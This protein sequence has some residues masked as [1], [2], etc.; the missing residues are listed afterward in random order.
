S[1]QAREMIMRFAFLLL[2]EAIL[3]AA[4]SAQVPEIAYDSTPNFLK[5]PEHIYMGEAVGVASNSKGNVFVYT[6]TGSTN[7][8]VGG[9]RTFTHGG[10]RLFEFAANGNFIKEIGV[11][12]YGF[13]FA[14][15]V[16]IDPQDNIWVID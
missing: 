11:G 9:S 16:R 7:A 14:H 4:T 8:T 10:A 15:A 2:A 1:R 3:A 5:L 13:V 12:M 6:R